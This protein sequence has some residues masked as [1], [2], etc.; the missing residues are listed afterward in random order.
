MLHPQARVKAAF[1]GCFHRHFR[2]AQTLAFVTKS[3]QGG[4]SPLKRFGQRVIGRNAREA[5]P[6]QSVWAGCIDVKLL[7][8]CWRSNGFKGKL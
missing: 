6:H 3:G 2:G 5:C 8:P 4:V 7:K 1:F